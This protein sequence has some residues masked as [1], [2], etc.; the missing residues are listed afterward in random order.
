MFQRNEFAPVE[1]SIYRGYF[2]G[3]RRSLFCRSTN[4][5]S[6]LS[7]R[8]HQKTT[9]MNDDSSVWAAAITWPTLA[10]NWQQPLPATTTAAIILHGWA[11]CIGALSA[12]RRCSMH[13]HITNGAASP[14]Q[15][16]DGVVDRGVAVAVMARGTVNDPGNAAAAAWRCLPVACKL[17]TGSCSTS[18]KK[19]GIYLQAGH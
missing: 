3:D 7:A 5:R 14:I 12:P 4:R 9:M 8:C 13:T 11:T 15:R 10:P 2:T 18:E 6:G 16:G 19:T 1:G 17:L